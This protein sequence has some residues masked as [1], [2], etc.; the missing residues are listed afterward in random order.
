MIER[1]LA[2]GM[3]LA[4]PNSHQSH[5]RVRLLRSDI[6]VLDAYG[7]SSQ[8]GPALEGSSRHFS[9]GRL[10]CRPGSPHG[11]GS[12]RGTANCSARSAAAGARVVCAF[13]RRESARVMGELLCKRWACFCRGTLDEASGNGSCTLRVKSE[14]AGI[15]RVRLQRHPLCGVR[16]PSAGIDHRPH[17]GSPLDVQ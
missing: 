2:V 11:W 3:R 1:E 12:R 7:R 6:F 4:S 15:V 9:W 8:L 10:S 13:C 16:R 5:L 17:P 14:R